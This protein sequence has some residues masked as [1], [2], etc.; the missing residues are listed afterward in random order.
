MGKPSLDS[1]C[2]AKKTNKNVCLVETKIVF[3]SKSA[4]RK[5]LEKSGFIL[6]AME[7]AVHRKDIRKMGVPGNSKGGSKA[8]AESHGRH[9]AE[10]RPARRSESVSIREL[11]RRGSRGALRFMVCRDQEHA[12]KGPTR[13]PVSSEVSAR[14]FGKRRGRVGG[15]KMN[16]ELGIAWQVSG[17]SVGTP[18]FWS[19]KSVSC[20]KRRKR[21]WPREGESQRGE[22]RGGDITGDQNLRI[23]GR[24]ETR[25]GE[26]EQNT[27][28]CSEPWGGRSQRS[29][30]VTSERM[31][32]SKT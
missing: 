20:K 28:D 23:G 4:G 17:A 30:A 19:S 9:L 31:E 10:N 15:A 16:R 5:R 14:V 12:P 2:R 29:L 21:G 24:V 6:D 18:S 26:E 25:G 22:W 3:R 27:A 11:K 32:T 8:M 7:E 13:D 1:I